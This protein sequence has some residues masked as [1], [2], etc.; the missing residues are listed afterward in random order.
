MAK[1]VHARLPEWSTLREF[2]H[3]K[4]RKVNVR[5]IH[6][7]FVNEGPTVAVEEE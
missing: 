4:P 2:Q 6:G 7:V 5:Y 1:P 3:S